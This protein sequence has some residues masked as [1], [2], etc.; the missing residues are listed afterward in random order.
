MDVQRT[1]LDKTSLLPRQST[2]WEILQILKR[3]GEATVDSLARELGVSL[4][5]VRLHLVVLE[6]DGLVARRPLREGPGRPAL[7]YR[8][9]E[10]AEDVF[11]KSYDALADRLLKALR[12]EFGNGQVERA[13]AVAA[14]SLAQSYQHRMVDKSLEERLEEWQRI[15]SEDGYAADWE[16]VEGGYLLHE[17]S[18]PYYR[19]AQRHREICTMDRR[20]LQEL[21]GVEVECIECLVDG[22]PRCTYLVR[23]TGESPSQLR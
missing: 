4:M 22:A 2:R 15:L 17:Y 3:Q 6:R 10:R 1:E 20:L 21:L 16:H 9:T 12:Q 8:P 13:C 5:A 7:A 18:C 23:P 11:P 14:S 19:V